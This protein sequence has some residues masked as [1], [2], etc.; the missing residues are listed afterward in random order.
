MSEPTDP[1]LSCRVED[2]DRALAVGQAVVL[3]LCFM[4]GTWGSGALAA[5]LAV[6]KVKRFAAFHCVTAVAVGQVLRLL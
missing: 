4:L 6:A 2:S 3:P 5:D 1:D